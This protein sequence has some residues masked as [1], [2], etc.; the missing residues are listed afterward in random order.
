MTRF[1]RFTY[2]LLLVTLV[3]CSSL[4]PILSTPT[5]AP[6][7]EATSTPQVL[8]TSTVPAESGPQILR[9]WLPPQFDPSAE[10]VSAGLLNQRLKDFEAEHPGITIEVRIK[11]NV[12][13]FL[14]TT[15]TR[16]LSFHKAG[17]SKLL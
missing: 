5:P 6:V 7:L 11:T 14:S 12:V 17:I 10:T 9:V 2:F 4:A 1:L 15:S 16:F 8:P 3:G 13:N